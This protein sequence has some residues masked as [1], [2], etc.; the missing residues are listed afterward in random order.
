MVREK[1][2]RKDGG[3]TER[4]PLCQS[5]G[6]GPGGQPI[7]P[8]LQ[9]YRRRS[10]QSPS[11]AR[12]QFTEPSARSREPQRSSKSALNRG[13]KVRISDMRQTLIESRAI[14]G[15]DKVS[16]SALALRADEGLFGRHENWGGHVAVRQLQISRE[17]HE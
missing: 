3:Q 6:S 16:V 17:I 13:P 15:G 8:N 2:E 12:R 9:D 1:A 14:E 7:C 5:Q 10:F 4:R 11:L